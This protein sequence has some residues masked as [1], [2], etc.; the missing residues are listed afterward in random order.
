[1]IKQ[2]NNTNKK[3]YSLK[4]NGKNKNNNWTVCSNSCK[5]KLTSFECKSRSYRLKLI[6]FKK[7]IQI[8]NNLWKKHKSKTKKLDKQSNNWR[9]KFLSQDN[10]R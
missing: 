8:N 4:I 1:M 5:N 9:Q 10:S 6:V 7:F 2:L 3:L